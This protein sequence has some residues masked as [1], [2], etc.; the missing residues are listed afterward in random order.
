[1]DKTSLEEIEWKKVPEIIKQW[2]PENLVKS[3]VKSEIVKNFKIMEDDSYAERFRDYYFVENSE[4]EDYGHIV[5]ELAGG[6][7]IMTGLRFFNLELDKAYVEVLHH[8]HE[9]LSKKI[10]TEIRDKI[11]ERY[12]IFNPFA[13]RILSSGN[14][15]KDFKPLKITEDLAYFAGLKESICQMDK[16]IKYDQVEVVRSE[17]LDFYSLYKGLLE[18]YIEENPG[19]EQFIFVHDKDYLKNVMDKNNLF[20][21]FIDEQWAGLIGVELQSEKYLD[22]YL[23]IEECLIKKFRGKHFAPAIQRKMIEQLPGDH[24]TI[25]YGEIHSNNIP[26]RRTAARVGRLKTGA[27]YFVHF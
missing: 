18:F 4:Q 25:I 20:T 6:N 10:L 17:N 5:I 8:T 23:V 13:F 12:K 9:K 3:L 14:P 26:S 24:H 16:P 19:S 11:K 7:Q 22:G 15:V 2:L 1:M 21:I 27:Y